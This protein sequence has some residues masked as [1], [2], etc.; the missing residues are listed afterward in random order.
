M[1]KLR[2]EAERS[3]DSLRFALELRRQGQDIRAK[4]LLQDMAWDGIES[5]SMALEQIYPLT[6]E[7]QSIVGSLSLEAYPCFLSIEELLGS[8]D[9]RVSEAIL[10]Q[11]PRLFIGFQFPYEIREQLRQYRKL[12]GERRLLPRL[13]SR[14]HWAFRL[15]WSDP[16]EEE[17]TALFNWLELG[18]HYR[19]RPDYERHHDFLFGWK[20][21]NLQ[22]KELTLRWGKD[23]SGKSWREQM[24]EDSANG[25]SSW[26]SPSSGSP[27]PSWAPKNSVLAYD[28]FHHG[29]Q[30]SALFQK[31]PGSGWSP[32]L[33]LRSSGTNQLI[34]VRLGELLLRNPQAVFGRRE[35]RKRAVGALQKVVGDRVITWDND[36][37]IPWE[38]GRVNALLK[39]LHNACTTTMESQDCGALEQ[40]SMGVAP[41][42]GNWTSAIVTAALR[43]GRAREQGLSYLPECLALE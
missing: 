17:L 28:R 37:V 10:E 4:R 14:K 2:R 31:T 25:I 20:L 8:L 34:Y 11:I 38:L 12:A 6:G 18:Q 27:L 41:I 29:I 9:P 13:K 42:E 33:E 19:T 26:S 35:R 40:F 16:L 15:R 32:S 24:F 1:D 21:H 39:Q 30:R 5:A 7:L 43:C 22:Y 3:G 23:L 36:F